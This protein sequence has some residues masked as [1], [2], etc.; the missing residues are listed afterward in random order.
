[1]PINPALVITKVSAPLF[2]SK[3]IWL[4]TVMILI[5]DLD[6]DKNEINKLVNDSWA[7]VYAGKL[8]LGWNLINETM[9]NVRNKFGWFSEEEKLV[10][11]SYDEIHRLCIERAKAGLTI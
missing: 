9:Q 3:L 4:L 1:M 11:N 8:Q 2:I 6:M 7:L 10:R 5:E